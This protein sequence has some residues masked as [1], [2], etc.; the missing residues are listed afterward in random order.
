MLQQ[1]CKPALVTIA[2]EA[3]VDHL[4]DPPR[5]GNS[6]GLSTLEKIGKLTSDVRRL[7]EK[8]TNHNTEMADMHTKMAVMETKLD[9]MAPESSSYLAVRNRFFSTYCRDILYRS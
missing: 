2:R 3:I 7:E 6:Q 5:W 8:T 1:W 4:V 9:I